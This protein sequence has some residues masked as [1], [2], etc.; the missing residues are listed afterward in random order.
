MWFSN[1]FSI[2]II[3]NKDEIF[4]GNLSKIKVHVAILHLSLQTKNIHE[5]RP[6]TNGGDAFSI[7]ITFGENVLRKTPPKF[8][9]LFHD[10]L[11]NFYFSS[12]LRCHWHIWFLLKIRITVRQTIRDDFMAIFVINDY[13][14]RKKYI[15]I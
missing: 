4:L 7:L 6:K 8:I 2:K 9:Y 13:G 11:I 3:K 10:H 5:N 14:Y 12:S 1:Y 15:E